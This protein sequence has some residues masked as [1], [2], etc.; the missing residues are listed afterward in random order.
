VPPIVDNSKVNSNRKGTKGKQGSN[1]LH[2]AYRI[3]RIQ[4]H[5]QSHNMFFLAETEV[6][7]NAQNEPLKKGNLEQA[8]N[9]FGMD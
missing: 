4:Q 2:F 6:L 7:D 1:M 9:A 5:Q 3:K 8:K